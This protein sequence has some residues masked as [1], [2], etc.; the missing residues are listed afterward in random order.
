MDNPRQESPGSQRQGQPL[1]RRSRCPRELGRPQAPAYLLMLTNT[2]VCFICWKKSL[3][4][5]PLVAGVKEQATMMKSDSAASLGV[6]T[7]KGQ[8]SVRRQVP[9]WRPQ[10]D[11]RPDPCLLLPSWKL[12]RCF[13]KASCLLYTSDNRTKLTAAPGVLRYYIVHPAPWSHT[14]GNQGQR[15]AGCSRSPPSGPN[16][17]RG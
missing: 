10:K 17:P 12:L 3:L 2:A 4:Q 16:V 14:W 6:D 7:G 9:G 15:G 1:S 5:S 13:L 11:G 8:G